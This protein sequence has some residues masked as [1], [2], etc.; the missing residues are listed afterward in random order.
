MLRGALSGTVEPTHFEEAGIAP[1]ARAE[2]LTVH[3]WLA[4]FRAVHNIAS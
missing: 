2:E 1:T 4:L 3:Q